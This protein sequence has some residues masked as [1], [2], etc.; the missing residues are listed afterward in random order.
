MKVAL[1]VAAIIVAVLV[2]GTL[3]LGT[4]DMPAPSGQV[5]KTIPADK[6]AH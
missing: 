1:I 5:E 6:L 4:I 3:V 2:V